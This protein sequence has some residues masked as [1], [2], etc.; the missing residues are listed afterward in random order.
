MLRDRLQLEN[1]DR[2]EY[3]NALSD[4]LFSIQQKIHTYKEYFPTHNEYEFFNIEEKLLA[5]SELAE[6]E[7]CMIGCDCETRNIIKCQKLSHL[8]NFT[9]KHISVNYIITEWF[10]EKDYR[11]FWTSAISSLKCTGKTPSCA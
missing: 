10:E 9:M 4:Q 2:I 3:W 1:L 7:K 6:V 5:L 11:E 8:L